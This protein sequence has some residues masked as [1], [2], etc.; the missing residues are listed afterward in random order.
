MKRDRGS[1]PAYRS[2]LTLHHPVDPSV[3]HG[4]PTP[5]GLRK[6][7]E[8]GQLPHKHRNMDPRKVT[9]REDD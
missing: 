6:V 5:R 2:K 9:S 8:D 7:R 4:Y 3:E 1:I